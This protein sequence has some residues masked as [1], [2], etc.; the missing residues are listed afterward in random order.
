MRTLA[1]GR[2]YVAVYA[3]AL[4][5][6]LAVL[7]RSGPVAGQDTVSYRNAAD[8]IAAAP[9]G[10][11][12]VF[13][14]LPPLLP[15]LMAV[16]GNDVAVA[17]ALVVVGSL[18]APA[19]FALGRRLDLAAAW[20]AGLAAS[21]W[22]HFLQWSP[23]L[24]TD[25]LGLALF[26]LALV[27][28]ARALECPDRAH[29]AG[30]GALIGF[31]LLARAALFLPAAAVFIVLLARSKR[32]AI[33]FIFAAIAVLTI[34]A[35]RNAI[36]IGEAVPYQGQTWLLLW[37]GTRWDETGRGTSGVDLI[38][39]A[40]YFEQPRE[41]RE[42]ILRDEYFAYIRS[43]PFDYAGRTAQ[44]LLWFWLPWFPEWSL[45]HAAVSGAS[46][47]PLYVLSLGGLLHC[48]RSRTAWLLVGCVLGVL[49]TVMLTIVDYD[50]R[51]RL[52]VEFA[53]LPLAA[54]G[55]VSVARK[56]WARLNG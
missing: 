1:V 56:G 32:S 50:N 15:I 42:R 39:P 6:R 4:A 26:A 22:P 20:P 54:V 19:A 29:G 37:A 10:A 7:S 47:L 25:G 17:S 51:Y 45:S 8:A 34:P 13:S 24:L 55:F 49:I 5:S 36:A 35:G 16:L 28:A 11:G 30:T 27:A 48:R 31:A 2:E 21:A 14:S 33:A 9:L 52:P 53:L 12:D 18:V 41:V 40:G 3:L 38:Y 44:K 23:Y 43:R 46:V